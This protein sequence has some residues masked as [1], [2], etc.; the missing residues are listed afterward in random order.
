[1]VSKVLTDIELKFLKKVLKL[2]RE[3]IVITE[4]C[5]NCGTPVTFTLRKEV[6][7]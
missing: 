7:K 2:E 5:P 1:M 6:K 3:V 4:I